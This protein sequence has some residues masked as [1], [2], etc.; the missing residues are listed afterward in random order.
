MTV[1]FIVN[2][3][4]LKSNGGE[5][6]ATAIFPRIVLP[7]L[8]ELNIWNYFLD[9]SFQLLFVQHKC[10]YHAK[11]QCCNSFLGVKSGTSTPTLFKLTILHF[12]LILM[13]VLIIRNRAVSTLCILT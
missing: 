3:L 1:A 9:Q 13:H 10:N 7:F 5:T 11:T 8:A 6:A 2:N 4:E 12:S